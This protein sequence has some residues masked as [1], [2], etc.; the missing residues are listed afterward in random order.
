MSVEAIKETREA[1][2][3][4]LNNGDVAA[5]VGAFAN[6]G[7]QMPPNAP[8]NV[9]RD[10]IQAWSGGMLGAFDVEFSLA[11]DEVESPVLTGH[12]NAVPSRSRS[13]LRAAASRSTTPASTSRS[14]NGSQTVAGRWPGTSGTATTRCPACPN[15]AHW[16][17]NRSRLARL[18]ALRQ[19]AVA[20]FVWRDSG[21][22]ELVLRYHSHTR[23]RG[24]QSY[25]F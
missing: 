13:L 1:H 10:S 17:A 21:G 9:G 15:R 12:L 22:R 11:P 5:W 7:V 3:A 20:S 14:T 2:V 23:A 16:A 4:A 25:G 6:D 24:R 8:A 18:G 19:L